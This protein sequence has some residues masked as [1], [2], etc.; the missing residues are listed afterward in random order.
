MDTFSASNLTLAANTTYW[1]VFQNAGT[2]YDYVNAAMGGSPYTSS[3]GW[4]LGS[5]RLVGL[6][7]E[8]YLPVFSINSVPEPS[9]C[10][11]L[12]FGAIP[13]LAQLYRGQARN[14]GWGMYPE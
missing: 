1:V 4:S 14:R 7:T 10:A 3:A 6:M 5:T 9:T 2:A 8:P 12:L 11:L 13:L